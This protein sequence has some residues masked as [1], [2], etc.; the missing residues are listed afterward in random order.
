MCVWDVPNCAQSSIYRCLAVSVRVITDQAIV[1]VATCLQ[2]ELRGQED[3]VTLL[4]RQVV[5]PRYFCRADES[6]PT[7]DHRC[8][9]VPGFEMPLHG[10]CLVGFIIIAIIH[11]ASTSAQCTPNVI[12]SPDQ[13]QMPFWRQICYWLAKRVFCRHVLF[14][15]C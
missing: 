11:A 10:S 9:A 3:V 13:G 2:S 5:L 8:I 1:G 14:H 15:F 4:F 6:I 12:Y 7:S